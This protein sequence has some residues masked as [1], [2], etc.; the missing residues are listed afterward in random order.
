MIDFLAEIS[1][2]RKNRALKPYNDSKTG[3]R[4]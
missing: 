2:M 4:D 1:A 3:W